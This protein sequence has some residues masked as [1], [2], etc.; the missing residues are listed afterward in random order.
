MK[1]WIYEIKQ[2][3]NFDEFE[4]IWRKKKKFLFRLLRYRSDRCFCFVSIINLIKIF[5]SFLFVVKRFL[6]LR[7]N[8]ELLLLLKLRLAMKSENY[9]F[10]FLLF[11]WR[12]NWFWMR[13][14]AW[15]VIWITF[16]INWY[17][18]IDICM[19]FYI[20]IER[21]IIHDTFNVWMSNLNN[22]CYHV[23]NE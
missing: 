22:W 20:E 3:T 18:I 19:I 23:L 7:K 9:W 4:E 1:N 10:E 2:K 11:F 8:S 14:R 5:V 17:S 15:A 13:W 12:K 6:L 16:S 21:S